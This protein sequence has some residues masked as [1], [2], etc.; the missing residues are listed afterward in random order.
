M[1]ILLVT[2]CLLLLTLTG[3]VAQRTGK[4]SI[5]GTVV[6]STT[7][8]VLREATVSLLTARDSAY[9]TFL[10][11]DGDGAFTL[12]NIQEGEYRLLITFVGYQNFSKHVTITPA[13]LIVDLGT[14]QMVVAALTLNEVTIKQERA[15]I[16]VK[17]DTLEFN[18]GSFKTQPNAQVEELLKKL[19]GVEVSRDGTIKAQGQQV[20][21]V[22]VDGKPFFGDDP[23][24]ATRNLP[25]DII[26]KVQ[27]YDQQSDQAAFSGIDDG[28]REKT[29]NLTT[30]RDKRKGYFG[31]NSAGVGTDGRYLGRLNVNRFNNGRQI[32]VI[33]LGN[34]LNQQG[35]TM[36]DMF[37]FGGG[38][39]G[40][41]SGG[42]GGPGNGNGPGGAGGQVIMG[43]G[44]RG[45]GSGGF[46][47]NTPNNI[48]E[49]LGGGINYR[50]AWGKRAEVAMSYFANQT[51]T[52][53][54]QQSRRENILPEASFT[55]DQSNT[56][57][58]R[59]RNH[60]FNMRLD[61]KLDSLTTLRFTPNLS[62]QTSKYNSLS[63][64]RAMTMAGRPLNSNETDYRS[65]GDGVSGFSNLL[66]MRKFRREGRTFSANLNT[67]LND[68]SILG[69]NQATNRFFGPDSVNARVN[70]LNQQSRQQTDLMNN[71]LTL[72]YTEPLSLSRKLEFRYTYAAN[73]NQADR[74]VTDY[75]EV[76]RQYDRFNPLLSNQFASAFAAHRGGVTFQNRRLR[77]S[78][79]IGV[80]VQEADL[81]VDNR[82]I[83]S[84]LNRQFVNVLP[85][86]MF[87]Y[88]F[89]RN[90]N[91]RINYRSRINAPSV[92]Q[93]QPV[94]DNTNPLNIRLGN[95]SLKPE[96][97]NTVMMM[98]NSF[99]TSGSRSLFAALNVNQI[100]N[101]IVNA[102]T[103]TNVGAQTTKPVNADGFYAVNGFMAV[104]RRL[105]NLKVNINWNTNVGLNRGVS[106][107]NNQSN[108][109]RN[110]IL[111]QGL[112]ANSSFNGKFEFNVSGNINYQ[113]AAYSLQSS[114]NTEFFTKTLEADIYYQLPFRLVLITDVTYL[115]NS[116]RS[117]GY[118]QNFALWNV[119]LA[120]QFFKGKQGELRLQVYD[121][122][123]QNRSLVRNV[124][125]TYI[126]DVQSRVLK[127]YFLLSFT[128]N[129]RKFG[130]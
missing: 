40:N 27:L 100:D 102:T 33:G 28:N 56:S 51:T 93:L 4:G 87:T 112:S 117:A 63:S 67:I 125:E 2:T 77:Y 89:G 71:T 22:L 32:S 126:E 60:R 38:G 128:Y 106:F 105:N 13:Q 122:L 95:P 23:K 48:V 82:S 75:N 62:W 65:N 109:S 14:V 37:N 17:Q 8:K 104:G 98:F 15:P 72:S 130:I 52:T 91:L 5:R 19:P 26:D 53:T 64:Q 6:D 36:Q 70:R 34:N 107:V 44:G 96:Y 101:R 66:L 123:N 90:R 11:T 45:G 7:G 119:A 129:L 58:N 83:D 74:S 39:L 68:Q 85:N 78:Y 79:G 46:G 118:N 12:K 47:N 54:E 57:R 86:A 111:G 16:A 114:Q 88:N 61:Y 81:R 1:R 116:G 20:N 73:S 110:W 42:F 10:I 41:Q 50:D 92:S 108:Y 31:Q 29:I 97:I 9:V 120:R 99:S 121:L 84:L 113:T 25:A 43:P 103:F 115:N 124:T 69:L 35:F 127:R 24:M 55:N 76:T 18:A 3:A 59:N 30:K 49:S 21:R 80:E 94:P